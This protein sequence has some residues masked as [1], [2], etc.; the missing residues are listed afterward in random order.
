M[1]VQELS[2]EHA[3]V[4]EGNLLRLPDHRIEVPDADQGL[5]EQIT[6]RLGQAP[7]APPDVKQLAAD[8]AVDRRRLAELMRAMEHQR[9]IVCVAPDLYFL[10]ESVDQV[11]ADLVRELSTTGG[12][13]TAQFRDRHQTSRKYAIPLLEYFDRTGITVRIGEMRRLKQPQ[14][15]KA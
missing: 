10:A 15:E 14:A 4:R 13:T 11:R 5:V 1:L 9:S 12:I 7:L 6:A 2:D 3:V 8:L